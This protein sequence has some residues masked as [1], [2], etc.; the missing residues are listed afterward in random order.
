MGKTVKRA[1]I[2]VL[3]EVQ[4]VAKKLLKGEN[5]EYVIESISSNKSG[6]AQSVVGTSSV[7][8]GGTTYKVKTLRKYSVEISHNIM[9]KKI[10]MYKRLNI[11]L[12]A[13]IYSLLQACISSE[14]KK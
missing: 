9:I 3:S 6:G 1:R 2:H 8:R 10:I 4:E 7:S 14:H 13:N 12:I 5:Q 11:V